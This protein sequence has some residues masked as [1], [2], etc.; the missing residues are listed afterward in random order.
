M[1]GECGVE[2]LRKPAGDANRTKT[3][4]FGFSL[5]A[6]SIAHACLKRHQMNILP[7]RIHFQHVSVCTYR[8]FNRTK[9]SSKQDVS[10]KNIFR[11]FAGRLAADITSSRNSMVWAV[12]D[13]ALRVWR[14][15][16][17]AFDVPSNV[18]IIHMSN[19]TASSSIA[20]NNKL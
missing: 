2:S 8:A 20:R 19:I 13:S 14:K 11:P 15:H 3:S 6:D 16:F 10:W 1:I 4:Q 17:F 18:H 12:S 9:W 5:A 7:T